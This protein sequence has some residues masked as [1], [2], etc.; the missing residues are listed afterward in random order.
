MKP[1]MFSLDKLRENSTAI[2]VPVSMGMH[3]SLCG[4]TVPAHL[5]LYNIFFTPPQT[6][7]AE[8]L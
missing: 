7:S 8:S 2:N 3:F 4:F 5:Y 1:L 6:A